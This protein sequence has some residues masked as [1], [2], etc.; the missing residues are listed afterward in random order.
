M[1]FTTKK[2]TVGGLMYLVHESM[3]FGIST[4]NIQATLNHTHANLPR[5]V[6]DNR[7]TLCLAD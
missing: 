6:K 2:H 1:P 4:D 7:M 3:H 5:G